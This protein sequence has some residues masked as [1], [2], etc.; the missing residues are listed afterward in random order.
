[1]SCPFL[2]A[3]P[4]SNPWEKRDDESNAAYARFLIYR[5][6]GVGRSL[7]LAYHSLVVSKRDKTRVSGQWQEDSSRYEWK[8]R[9][10]AWD[11]Y[12][13]TEVA[14]GVV[15][16]Y[17]NALDKAFQRIIDSLSDAKMKPDNWGQV[18]GSLTTLGEFI[19]QETVATIR[20]NNEG[21][22]V[23]SIG[24]PATAGISTTISVE[25]GGTQ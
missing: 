7:D 23:P 12:I 1:M 25:P 11:V 9:A 16:K 21:D 22:I 13:L 3:M 10:D 17:V 19:P 18:I 15:V 24:H 5:N 2:I 4:K 6:L 8:A 20:Q 14:R